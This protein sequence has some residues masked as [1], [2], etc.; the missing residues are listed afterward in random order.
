MVNVWPRVNAQVQL[1]G[2]I[3]TGNTCFPQ[4]LW[5][6]CDSRLINPSD[7]LAEKPV[8]R[9]SGAERGIKDLIGRGQRTDA[10]RQLRVPRWTSWDTVTSAL[11][12]ATRDISPGGE[13]QRIGSEQEA[14]DE[15]INERAFTEETDDCLSLNEFSPEFGTCS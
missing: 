10:G 9:D 15:D 14:A 7:A 8:F 1:Y 4:I 13:T 12:A 6:V 11:G 3:Q 5:S 2:R